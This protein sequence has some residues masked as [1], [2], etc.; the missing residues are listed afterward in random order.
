MDY[1]Q[2]DEDSEPEP[3]VVAVLDRDGYRLGTAVDYDAA[4]TI[5]A[6]M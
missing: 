3:T 1:A 4:L 5:W 2:Y 6:T